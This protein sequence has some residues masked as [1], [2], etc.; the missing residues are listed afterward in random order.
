MVH[1]SLG[2]P[3]GREESD[4]LCTTCFLWSR[5]IYILSDVSKSLLRL[6]ILLPTMDSGIVAEITAMVP[7]YQAWQILQFTQRTHDSAIPSHYALT[8]CFPRHGRS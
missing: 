5:K 7:M 6:L 1:T 3:V 8:L 2:H 4:L